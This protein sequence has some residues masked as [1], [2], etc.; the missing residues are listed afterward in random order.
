M[1]KKFPHCQIVGIDLVPVS[2]EAES[3]PS[4]CQ[5]EIDDVELG[6][7]HFQNRFDLVHARLLAMGLRDFQK[8]MI[9]I[10]SCLKP[11]GIVIW[12]EPDQH[13][14]T[15]DIHVHR[16]LGSE[17]HPDGTWIGRILYGEFFINTSYDYQETICII[18][19]NKRNEASGHEDIK[20][21]LCCDGKAD[22]WWNMGGFSNRPR[23][24]SMCPNTNIISLNLFPIAGDVQVCI[25]R[26]VH[27]RIVSR[28]Q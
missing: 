9:D 2:I 19:T 7:Q 27:G 23:N 13:F 3:I 1:A 4:N 5:F 6:L 21:R 8:S 11:G 22:R 18:M 15:S 25:Y 28:L 10:H 20:K 17:A 14:F 24:V 16:P 12:M 26:S